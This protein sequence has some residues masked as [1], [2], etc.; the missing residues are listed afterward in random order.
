MCG[1]VGVVRRPRDRGPLPTS[2]RSLASPSSAAVRDAR[3]RT[4]TAAIVDRLRTAAPTLSKAST[5]SCAGAPG[6]SALLGDPPGA[7]SIED[8]ARRRSARELDAIEA[9]LD[10][11]RGAG[12]GRGARSRPSTPRSYVR[13]DAVWAVGHDRLGTARAVAD[14]AGARPRPRAALDALPVG[15]GRALRARPPRGP[16]PRLR[17]AAP[18]RAR[19]TRSTSTSRPSRG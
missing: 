4:A 7:R 12:I 19:A 5:V 9:E 13:R 3:W 10:G 8:R 17:R 15:P 14:L 6:V 18:P 1:I 16:R 2:A 11:D